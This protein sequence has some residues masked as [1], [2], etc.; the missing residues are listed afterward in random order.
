[1]STDTLREPKLLAESYGLT[2]QLASIV[3]AAERDSDPVSML[4]LGEDDGHC[5]ASVVVLKGQD[6]VT[7]FRQW[8][9]RNKVLGERTS[10]M[11]GALTLR[12]E[13]EIF[14][15]SRL[16]LLAGDHELSVAARQGFMH[17]PAVEALVLTEEAVAQE[18][19]ALLNEREEDDGG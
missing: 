14:D 15:E 7:L 12:A 6:T 11:V 18:A 19:K 9:E 3:R 13:L 4:T 16:E 8:A 5:E 17:R 1:M 2:G 10:G